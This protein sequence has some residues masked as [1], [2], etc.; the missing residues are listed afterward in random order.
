MPTAKLITL[1]KD[2]YEQNLL[3]GC[4][5]NK[6]CLWQT[7]IYKAPHHLW[8]QFRKPTYSND[9]KLGFFVSTLTEHS[10]GKQSL[11]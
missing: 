4:Q 10:M 5:R 8:Q 7:K 6:T 2:G 3:L 11:L 9:L 1:L